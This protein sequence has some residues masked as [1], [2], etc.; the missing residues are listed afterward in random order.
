[1]KFTVSFE[2][3]EE[4]TTLEK[5]TAAGFTISQAEQVVKQMLLEAVGEELL[6]DMVIE[7]LIVKYKEEN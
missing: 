2:I 6:E 7:N 3:I 1:M 4:S 5:L